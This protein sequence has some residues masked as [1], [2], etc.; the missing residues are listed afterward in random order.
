[1]LKEKQAALGAVF[2]LFLG[3]EAAAEY[4]AGSAA[5]YA[6]TKHSA[7][8]MDRSTLGRIELSGADRLEFLHRMST[9]DIRALKPGA[10]LQTVLT[11][12][13]AR[14]IELLS[15]YA[16]SEL[17]LCVT[18][19]QNGAKVLSW[20]KRNMFFRDKVKAVD[21]SSRTVQLTLF[22]PAKYCGRCPGKS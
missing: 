5:E 19:P 13:E 3:A 15:V 9:N 14:I 18:S 22:G 2:G 17:L 21:I 1:V 10:G 16:Q 6:A 11:T 4:A 20:L 8:L 7:G 12:P